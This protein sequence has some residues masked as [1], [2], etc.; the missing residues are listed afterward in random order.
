MDSGDAAVVAGATDAGYNVGPAAESDAES[1][2]FAPDTPDPTRDDEAYG[3]MTSPLY[4][5]M[6]SPLM[7]SSVGDESNTSKATAAETPHNRAITMD[8]D[9]TGSIVKSRTV[10]AKNLGRAGAPRVVTFSGKDAGVPVEL[11]DVKGTGT[12]ASLAALGA[13]EPGYGEDGRAAGAT[14]EHFAWLGAHANDSQYA[15]GDDDDAED[16][17]AQD[18]DE[19]EAERPD[20]DAANGPASGKGAPVWKAHEFDRASQIEYK[21]GSLHADMMNDLSREVAA[22]LENLSAMCGPSVV[23]LTAQDLFEYYVSPQV[24]PRCPVAPPPPPPPPPAGAPRRGAP[25]FL[26]GGV[27]LCGF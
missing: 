1:D 25:H 11:S 26:V 22:T 27:G 16:R 8:T 18:D 10:A 17:D 19:L 20:D 21:V 13:T 3:E 12:A 6:T 14:A 9:Y 24:H 7:P 4:G 15:S 23:D 5:E 2:A